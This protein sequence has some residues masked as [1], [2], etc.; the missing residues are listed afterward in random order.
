[1]SVVPSFKERDI[2]VH[3]QGT[4]GMSQPEM[5]RI[6]GRVSQ[7]LRSIPNITN[8]SAQVGRAIFG[9]QIVDVNSAELWVS[10]DASANYDKTVSAIQDVV[11]GYPGLQHSVGTYLQEE[12]SQAMPT[13]NKPLDVRV[14]GN[15][16]AGLRASAQ[17]IQK[18]IS[19]IR[20][21]SDAQINYPI[22]DPT[23]EIEVNL[24]A[25]QRFGVK[26]GDVRRAAATMFSGLQVGSLFE[27]QKV[28]DV[29]VWSTPESRQSISDVLNLQVDTPS[30]GHVR[31][32]DVAQVRLTSAPSVVR[33]DAV[34]RYMDI[35]VSVQ[36][37]SLGAVAADIQSELRKVQL[38]LEYHAEVL[39]DYAAQ[40]ATFTRVLS[41]ALAALLGIFLL[42]QA[43]YRS[44][45]LAF[46]A[47]LTLPMALSGGVFVALIGG[48]IVSLGALAG[49]LTVLGM[50]IRNGVLMTNH[51]YRIEQAN[52][53][54]PRDELVVRGTVERIPSLVTSALA[55][56]LMLL[57]AVFLGDVPGLE[58]VRPMVFIVLGGELTT[59]ILDLFV[60][61]A[62]YLR[63]GLSR[64]ADLELVPVPSSVAAD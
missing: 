48:G 21:I 1:M 60:L 63:Y 27:E 47:V 43:A 42:L 23:L 40:Q 53:N 20:G 16:D 44:W 37:R 58:V 49:L 3:L 34:K 22:Y 19:G 51:L 54:A 57:P 39:G 52:M 55:T 38:P 2:V 36:G 56:F 6:S 9:D 15:T 13:S 41:I 35:M 64:E 61:P 45:R 12:T 32:G 7:E 4:A 26:P 59:I 24:P 11:S 50:V 18:A 30:G 8:V 10:M 62:L 46:L 29:V 14:Y 33:H 5:S 28:F 25:A 17:G 31:L